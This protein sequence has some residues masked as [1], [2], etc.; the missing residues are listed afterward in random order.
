M[1]K[2]KYIGVVVA[3]L[4]IIL[5]QAWFT[6]V[7]FGWFAVQVNIWQALGMIILMKSITSMTSNK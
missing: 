1:E 7:V 3:S 5:T 6:T 4:A 2:T